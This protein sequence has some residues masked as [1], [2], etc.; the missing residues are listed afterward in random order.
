MNSLLCKVL[1]M[2]IT[3]KQY[4][5]TEREQEPTAAGWSNWNSF[6][7]LLPLQYNRV[8]SV[9]LLILLQTSRIHVI[10]RTI[11]CSNRYRVEY[12]VG[13]Q[14]GARNGSIDRVTEPHK[15]RQCITLFSIQMHHFEALLWPF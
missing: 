9:F 1:R 12:A 3:Q 14:K 10:G 4:L 15:F 13:K 5:Q 11:L 7:L 8:G 6:N 2:R